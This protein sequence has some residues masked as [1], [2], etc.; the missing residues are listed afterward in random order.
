MIIQLGEQKLAKHNQDRQYNFMQ[1]VFLKKK[2][3][4][5]CTMGSG[6]KPPPQEAGEF[7]RILC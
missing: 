1:Y 4:M 7:S 6:T 3:Y 5:W 2:T